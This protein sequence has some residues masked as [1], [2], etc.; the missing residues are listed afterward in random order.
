[1]KI[2]LYKNHFQS[3]KPT[4]STNCSVDYSKNQSLIIVPEIY[5]TEIN[6]T[7][8]LNVKPVILN[9]D[10]IIENPKKRNFSAISREKS[11]IEIA[12]R[13]KVNTELKFFKNERKRVRMLSSKIDKSLERFKRLNFFSNK[14]ISSILNNKILRRNVLS[15]AKSFLS[16]TKSVPMKSLLQ[17]E[18]TIKKNSKEKLV[19]GQIIERKL[20]KGCSPVI[21]MKAKSNLFVFPKKNLKKEKINMYQAI[22]AIRPSEE[23]IVPCVKKKIRD[24]KTENLSYSINDK[25]LLTRKKVSLMKYEEKFREDKYPFVTI[26]NIINTKI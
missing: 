10:E 12:H 25:K 21:N 9:S 8:N 4:R 11:L 6:D 23:K 2:C 20:V 24:W 15:D 16:Q 22:Y 17:I 5:H 18:G 1:M 14:G 13:K 26:K 7:T 3:L 19:S